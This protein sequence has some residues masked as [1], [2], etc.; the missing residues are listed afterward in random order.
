MMDDI[1]LLRRYARENSEEAFTELVRRYLGL[2]YHAACRQLGSEAHAADD[3]TQKVFTLFARKASA[4]SGHANPAAW[5]HATTRFAALEVLRAERRRRAREQQAF[6]MYQIAEDSSAP[7]WEQLQP[8][9]DDALARLEARDRE[10]VLLRFFAGL[11]LAEIGA[12]L[13]V[14]ENTARMRIERALE[15]LR[16]HLALRGVASSA[17]ALATTLA[18][19]SALAAP[20]GLAASVTASALAGG[21]SAAAGT[22]A[23]L[24]F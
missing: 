7:H 12:R 3:V 22:A 18:Q 24:S 19:H 4:L 8:V 20:A 15:K 16:G 11:P 9:I 17:A 1:E 14:T 2:V 5:L 21:A 6:L 23:A 13:R 10:A